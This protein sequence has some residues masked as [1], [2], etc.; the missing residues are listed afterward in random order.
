[1][2]ATVPVLASTGP[3]S[4]RTPVLASTSRTLVP[5]TPPKLQMGSW[6]PCLVPPSDGGRGVAGPHQQHLCGC[7]AIT[8]PTPWREKKGT[9][10]LHNPVLASTEPDR[11][12]L[13][14]SDHPPARSGVPPPQMN[15]APQLPAAGP[16]GLPWGGLGAA[17]YPPTGV[18]TTALCLS[19]VEIES[20]FPLWTHYM[21]A[22]VA[23]RWPLGACTVRQT[24]TQ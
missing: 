3:W 18:Q 11:P 22:R 23:W 5:W 4:T 1:M 24:V 7:G 2:L 15:F 14:T 17:W 10:N 12:V 9:Q 21:G 20:K 8:W 13:N 19:P 6:W 16:G